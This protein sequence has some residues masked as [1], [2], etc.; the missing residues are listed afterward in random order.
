[1]AIGLRKRASPSAVIVLVAML[2]PMLIAAYADPGPTNRPPEVLGRPPLG[3]MP[4]VELYWDMDAQDPDGDRPG[5]RLLQGPAGATMN[6]TT[7]ELRWTPPPGTEPI[8]VQIAFSVEVADATDAVYVNFTVR[9]RYP[10]DEPPAIV[11]NITRVIAKGETETDLGSHM[12]D[13]DDPLSNLTWRVER[14]DQTGFS[15]KVVG[16]KMLI[17]PDSGEKGTGLLTLVL[18]DPSGLSD[19][20][21]VEVRYDGTMDVVY[22]VI[23]WVIIIAIVALIVAMVTLRYRSRSMTGASAPGQGNQAVGG[24]WVP[25]GPPCAVEDILV[26]YRD[27]RMIGR[28]G[29]AGRMTQDADLMSGMLI[30]VQGLVQDG[31]HDGGE[32]ESIKYG[33]SILLVSSGSFVNLV[34]VVSGTPDDALIEEMRAMVHHIEERYTDSISNWTGDLSAFSDMGEVV[35]PILSRNPSGG[36]EAKGRDA[37]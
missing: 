32:L 25:T 6:G 37:Q 35:E 28:F 29:R 12:S 7:G 30:A 5:F 3:A 33:D 11:G 16:H 15:A 17:A 1:M 4:G 27:G 23:C 10:P 18:E 24:R 26:V 9:L 36:R 20:T 19:R 31:L 13:A 34:A 21:E 8:S 14:Q 22:G 2:M